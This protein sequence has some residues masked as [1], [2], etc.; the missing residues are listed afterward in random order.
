MGTKDLHMAR[1]RISILTP[2][3]LPGDSS[4]ID[5]HMLLPANNP[6]NMVIQKFQNVTNN[7]ADAGALG[8]CARQFTKACIVAYMR[9]ES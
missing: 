2:L 6:H 4:G 5:W 1:E 7:A 9:F 3:T 8:R